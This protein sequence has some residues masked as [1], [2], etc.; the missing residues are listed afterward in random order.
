[1]V[2]KVQLLLSAYTALGNALKEVSRLDDPHTLDVKISL[3]RSE[4][5][6][7]LFIARR[8]EQEAQQKADETNPGTCY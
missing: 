8:N 1:M 4:L 6:D 7:R 5:K 3:L 2:S